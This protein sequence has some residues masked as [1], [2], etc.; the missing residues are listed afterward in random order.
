MRNKNYFM[1][2]GMMFKKYYCS[3]CQTLLKKEKTHRVV[4][5]EDVDYFRYQR[6][7]V[8]PRR[9][10]DVYEYRLRCSSCNESISFEEQCI[11]ERIQRL[12]N[13][14]VLSEKEI[15]DNYEV[16]KKK[17]SRRIAVGNSEIGICGTGT[18]ITGTWFIKRGLIKSIK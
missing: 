18:E 3:K 16:C 15:E 13:K 4:S 8:F 9:D 6:I 5:K 11:I 2:Y 10:W 17:E 7:N 1:P 14:K 12:N